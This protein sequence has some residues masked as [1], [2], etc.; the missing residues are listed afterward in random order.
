[1]LLAGTS[2]TEISRFPVRCRVM[3]TTDTINSTWL[4]FFFF[5]N[6]LFCKVTLWAALKLEFTLVQFSL[7]LLL[8]CSPSGEPI[9]EM[10][11]IFPQCAV[12][13]SC[14][15]FLKLQFHISKCFLVVTSLSFIP[16]KLKSILLF[17]HSKPMLSF[18]TC[19][20]YLNLRHHHQSSFLPS[21]YLQNL[22]RKELMLIKNRSGICPSF[23]RWFLSPWHV[24]PKSVFVCLG[25][26]AT[27]EKS[28][29]MTYG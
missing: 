24:L 5:C 2:T 10:T 17:F 16:G 28:N 19:I 3:M 8:T 6:N 11:L 12:I 15:V 13:S 29:I 25:A 27:W 21:P 18:A 23:W 26:L 14:A 7:Y 20:L 9:Y 4:F 22:R 1:M